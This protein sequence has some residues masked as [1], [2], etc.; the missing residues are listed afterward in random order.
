M[1]D[2]MDL[3]IT[4]AVG[5]SIQIALFVT[6]F[7]VLVGWMINV[8]MSLYY[9]TFETAVAFVAVFITALVLNDGELNWLEGAMLFSTYVIIAISFFYYPDVKG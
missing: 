1:K 5:L 7:M 2:K 6:P 8:P 9:L 4:V 3:A